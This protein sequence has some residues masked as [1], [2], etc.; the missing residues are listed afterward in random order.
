MK[1]YSYFYSLYITIYTSIISNVKCRYFHWIIIHKLV[2]NHALENC[3]KCRSHV[4]SRY[5]A[6][7]GFDKPHAG[8]PMSY[9]HCGIHDVFHTTCGAR[10]YNIPLTTYC[11]N[12]SKIDERVKSDAKCALTRYPPFECLNFQ[13]WS[14][15]IEYYIANASTHS[16]CAK[17]NIYVC[18]VILKK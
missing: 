17:V 10:L 14:V 2:R 5:S 6:T 11:G 3:A 4:Y 1:I 13:H 12:I 7:R 8:T 16:Y 18:L 15:Y 9:A